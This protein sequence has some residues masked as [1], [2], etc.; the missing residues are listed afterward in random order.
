ME[1]LIVDGTLDSLS[2]IAKYVLSAANAAGLDKKATYKLRLAIDEIATNI[3]VHGYTESGLSGSVK[4]E[5]EVTRD[6]LRLTLQDSAIPFDP[7]NKADP[8]CL[9]LPLEERAIG[10]LGVFLAK[11]GID[12]FEYEFVNG[13]NRNILTVNLK[14]NLS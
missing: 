2:A 5:A 12:D 10:G 11:D 7:T 6:R 8:E 9:E 4:I 1:P 3:I 13:C 14:E